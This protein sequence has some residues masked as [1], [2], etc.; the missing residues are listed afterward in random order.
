MTILDRIVETKRDELRR[1]KSPAAEADLMARVRDLPPTGD[2]FAAC[3]SP[4]EVRIIA[5]IKKASPSVGLIRKDFDP[6]AIARTYEANGAACL[7]VLT[8]ETYF[9]GTLEYLTSVKAAVKI[10]VL[11][12]EF[13]ID[14][15]QLLEARAAG[16][17][18]VLLI[19]EILPGDS[20]NELYRHAR[21]LGLHVLVEFH[22]AEQLSRVFDSGA[23]LIGINNR[24]LRTFETR[25]SH[26][27]EL[28]NSIPNHIAVVGESGI[29]THDDLKL[30]GSV[31]V[32]AVLVG[33][34]LMREADIGAALRRLRG[35]E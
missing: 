9:Q 27:V 32:K 2:F 15:F 21:E 11:R 34:S 26:T 16:A 4:G 33:E 10:P 5:E 35:R 30:L 13:I 6:V 23:N 28:M 19:A 22:D 25:L 24:D 1:T 8:D 17:D 12:K 31:G 14:Q 7:S 20:M 18:A 3:T 29:R